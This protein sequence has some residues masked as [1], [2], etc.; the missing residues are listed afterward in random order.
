MPIAQ[1]C[2]IALNTLHAIQIKTNENKPRF[3]PF[4][5]KGYKPPAAKSEE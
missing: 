5:I 1:S 4:L 2:H 3:K